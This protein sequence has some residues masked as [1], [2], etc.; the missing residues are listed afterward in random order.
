MFLRDVMKCTVRPT[1]QEG[2]ESCS[3]IC[4]YLP[5]DILLSTMIY[6]GMSRE[7]FPHSLDR[8]EFFR[9]DYSTIYPQD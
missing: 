2:N 9:L 4:A 6:Y 3:N 8:P 7:T 5:P 1:F